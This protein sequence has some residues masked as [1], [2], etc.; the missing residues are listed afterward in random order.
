[1]Q[2]NTPAT[3]PVPKGK[4]KKASK[5]KKA[6]P[7]PQDASQNTNDLLM[8]IVSRL[9]GMDSNLG[10]MNVQQG[11]LSNRIA[12]VEK[13]AKKQHSPKQIPSTSREL[14]FES[15]TPK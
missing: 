14:S 6:T 7:S 13:P 9:D 11:Q 10:A 3:T 5:A 1:V 8:Q 2:D 15:P 4:K 12:Q